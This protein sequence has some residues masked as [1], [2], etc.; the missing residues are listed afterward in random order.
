MKKIIFAL[1]FALV[2]LIASAED[3]NVYISNVEHKV[4]YQSGKACVV[5]TVTAKESALKEYPEGFMVGVRPANRIYDLLLS[6]S[7][8]EKKVRLSKDNPS[9]EVI[10]YCDENSDGRKACSREEFVVTSRP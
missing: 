6:N 9:A 10:F 8:S 5:V 2:T 7:R 3:R 4:F 1:F